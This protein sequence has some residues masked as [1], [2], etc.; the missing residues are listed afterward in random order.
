MTTKLCPGQ[1]KAFEMLK[2]ASSFGRVLVLFGNTGLGKSTVLH[3]AH[4]EF[5][6][7]FLNMTDFMTRSFF[8]DGNGRSK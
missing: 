3:A 1:Q 5:G 2:H 6:G 4:N 7:S 8:R